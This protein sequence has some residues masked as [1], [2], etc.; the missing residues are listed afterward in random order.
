M[1][2]LAIVVLA[3]LERA[4]AGIAG[5]VMPF[6]EFQSKK[7]QD[8]IE[9]L[10]KYLI[11]EAVLPAHP[12]LGIPEKPKKTT[13]VNFTKYAPSFHFNNTNSGPVVFVK[14]DEDLA[15]G[16][17]TRHMTS[18]G[19]FETLLMKPLG[20]LELK[21]DPKG[22]VS[23]CVMALDKPGSS[24]K[25]WIGGQ[26]PKV[27]GGIIDAVFNGKAFPSLM[28]MIV[29]YNIFRRPVIEHDNKKPLIT[30]KELATM[31]T[32]GTKLDPIFFLAKK[33]RA[34]E[35]EATLKNFMQENAYVTP[36]SVMAVGFN[37]DKSIFHPFSAAE[38]SATQYGHSLL[39]HGA[40]GMT[41][42]SVLHQNLLKHEGETHV[43]FAQLLATRAMNDPFQKY[44]W[45]TSPHGL[46]WFYGKG[47][48]A[49]DAVSSAGRP[50]ATKED[51]EFTRWESFL[52]NSSGSPDFV[53]VGAQISAAKGYAKLHGVVAERSP[54]VQQLTSMYQ[55]NP[56]AKTWTVDLNDTEKLPT[57]ANK[58]RPDQADAKG[59][60]IASIDPSLKLLG[61]E[62]TSRWMVVDF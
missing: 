54:L 45:M 62:K 53:F 48:F 34:P 42:P 32:H 47:E 18:G 44:Q 26:P 11:G 55:Q 33:D 22:T 5:F 19:D 31:T 12:K 36:A 58:G 10:G 49:V 13:E 39:E 27:T 3:G 38:G 6:E 21:N 17:A 20:L 50:E 8:Y 2:P 1:K 37:E 14:L 57:I 4:K 23:E 40:Y 25:F 56:A 28:E 35:L 41:S 9:A 43:V 15:Q 52:Q 46:K 60:V 24:R 59:K 29:E 30:D 16:G 61:L 7:V 51:K